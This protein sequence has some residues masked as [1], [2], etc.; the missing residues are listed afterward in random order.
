MGRMFRKN[1]FKE[2]YMKNWYKLVRII[3]L[4]AVIGFSFALTFTSCANDT[5]SRGTPLNGSWTMGGVFDINISGS[6]GVITEIV[7]NNY[8]SVGTMYF[9]NLRQTGN[10]TWSGQE[11]GIYTYSGTTGWINTT[12]TL[13]SNGRS[14]HSS[15]FNYTFNRR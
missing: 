7:N 15:A 5:T 10:S 2:F 13:A 9:R 12:I 11:L 8:I 6:N 3:V 4:A 1:I 14:F